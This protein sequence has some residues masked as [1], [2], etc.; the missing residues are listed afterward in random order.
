MTV[1]LS[2]VNN[3]ISSGQ[4][5][6]PRFC[7]NA[8]RTNKKHHSISFNGAFKPLNEIEW[9]FLLVLKY[10]TRS[11]QYTVNYPLAFE[12]VKS[13]S[14]KHYRWKTNILNVICKYTDNIKTDVKREPLLIES[15]KPLGVS[16]VLSRLLDRAIRSQSSP[17][18]S[19]TN[20]KTNVK[21]YR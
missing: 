19:K 1:I 13:S 5:G 17:N 2:A 7:S 4:T 15:P 16:H 8:L 21:K 18:R 10:A 3:T 20:K 14:I 9:C 12:L 6:I 11:F